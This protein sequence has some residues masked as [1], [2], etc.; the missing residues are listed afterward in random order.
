MSTAASAVTGRDP[1]YD[2]IFDLIAYAKALGVDLIEN[3]HPMMEAARAK[4][5]VQPGTLAEVLGVADDGIGKLFLV[6]RPHFTALGFDAVDTVLRDNELYSSAIYYEFYPFKQL[7]KSI[8][9]LGGAEHRHYRGVVQ[10]LFTRRNVIDW[11]QT[12]WIEQMVDELLGTLETLG[13][14][15]LNQ[16]FCARL[17]MHTITRAFGLPSEDA[18]DF[19]CNLLLGLDARISPA[20]RAGADD[21]VN[22]VLRKAVLARRGVPGDDIISRLLAA[23]FV[24]EDGT[25]RVLSEA[26]IADFC[27]VIVLAGGGTTWRQLGITLVC[28]LSDPKQFEAVKQDRRLIDAAI[29]EA[30]R[31]QN[32]TP[33]LYRLTTQDAVLGGVRIPAGSVV[34]YSTA[35][36]NRDPARWTDP[37][38]YDLFRAPQRH[39]A[40]AAGPHTCLGMF[41]ALAEMRIAINALIDRLPDLRFDP[42]FEAPRVTGT[43]GMR[44]A[45]HLNVLYG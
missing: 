34:E 29:N 4:G 14:A 42:A 39:L 8:L 6:D 2:E 30:L 41:V 24:D 27:K 33:L 26:E 43:L 3:P 10:S 32:S 15:D 9:H 36:A 21:I 28:L 40:F 5:P 1:R 16:E 19:R 45:S 25:S 18:L 44:G 35:A 20:E 22:G 31:W 38:R 13:R 11:W 12:R 23:E 7:G 17:P 37:D